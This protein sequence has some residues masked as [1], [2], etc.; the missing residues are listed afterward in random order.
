MLYALK[1]SCRLVAVSVLLFFTVGVMG[2]SSGF[3][4]IAPTPP[5]KYEKMGPAKGEGTGM[6]GFIST[7]YNFFPLGLNSRVETAYQEALK[8]KYLWQFT[9][10]VIFKVATILF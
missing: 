9:Q 8:N 2:C 4:T 3:V 1:I 10:L 7:A 6:M 5:P